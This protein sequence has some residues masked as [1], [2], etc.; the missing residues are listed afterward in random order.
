M[1]LFPWENGKPLVWDATCVSTVATSNIRNSAAEPGAAATEAESKKM[2]KYSDLSADYK[3][4]P[5]GFET[6]GHWGNGTI[7]F[8]R[9]LGRELTQATGEPRSSA[10]LRQR[11][12][13]AIQRGNAAAVRGTVPMSE[14]FL[15][16]SQ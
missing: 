5:L 9:R 15:P 3:F 4:T 12:S 2:E 6:M 8:V 16:S 7:S 11:L 13:I 14:V 1:T 10:F